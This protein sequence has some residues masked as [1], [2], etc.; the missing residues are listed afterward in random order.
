MKHLWIGVWLLAGLLVAGGVSSYG[1]QQAQEAV[2]A[3]LEQAAEAGLR[4]E[5]D[6]A[7]RFFAAAQA[8]WEKYRKF[9]AAFVEHGPMEEV[10]SLFGE[11]EQYQK[12]ENAL[13]FA[14]TCRR[15]SQMTQAI[16]EAHRLS[17]WNLL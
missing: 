2:T 4:E 13:L 9:L 8:R 15:L 14:G 17:W 1:V 6:Q 16:G 12:G 7:E 3:Q 10:D 5:W 11:L